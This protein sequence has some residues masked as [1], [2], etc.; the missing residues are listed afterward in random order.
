MFWCSRFKKKERN[1]LK[2]ESI[3]KKKKNRLIISAVKN[4]EVVTWAKP[5]F[6]FSNERRAVLTS[7][8]G[9]PPWTSVSTWE[10]QQHDGG[11]LVKIQPST[12]WG[13]FL[14]VNQQPVCLYLEVNGRFYSLFVPSCVADDFKV[15][16]AINSNLFWLQVSFNECFLLTQLTALS[17]V[18]SPCKIDISFFVLM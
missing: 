11:W 13:V 5:C 14:K 12:C 7:R 3:A 8:R 2:D 4:W 16:A 9:G 6:C 1:D 18:L 17:W 10:N 15:T